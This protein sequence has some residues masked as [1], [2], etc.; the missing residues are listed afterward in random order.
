MRTASHQDMSRAARKRPRTERNG[1]ERKQRTPDAQDEHRR[2]EEEQQDLPDDLPE[3]VTEDH[4][5]EHE[6]LPIDDPGRAAPDPAPY[7][8]ENPAPLLR[9]GCANRGLHVCVPSA[10]TGKWGPRE[11][12]RQ[13]RINSAAP[14]PVKRCT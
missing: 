13:G 3:G 11:P 14:S 7:R 1:V 6:R 4:G 2:R 8:L 12:L 9:L 5:S 10:W